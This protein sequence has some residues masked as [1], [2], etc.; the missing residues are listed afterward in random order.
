MTRLNPYISFNGTAREAVEFY[1]SVFG[2]KITMNTFKESHAS[3]DPSDDDKI[4][5]AMLESENGIV[6]M[7]ADTPKGMQYNPGTNISIS[8]SGEDD[9]EL[10]GYF[11]KLSVGGKIDQPLVTAPWGDKFGMLTDQFGTHWLVN[12]S[13]KKS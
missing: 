1:K 6:L 12:I 7:C 9:S 8:L 4:M 10:S 5:H 3:M 2:G 13:S 11:E